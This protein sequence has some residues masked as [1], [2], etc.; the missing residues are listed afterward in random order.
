MGESLEISSSLMEN[1]KNIY[2][3]HTKDN[4]GNGCHHY[5]LEKEIVLKVKKKKNLYQQSLFLPVFKVILC[6]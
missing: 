5:S 6:I 1:L 2:I 4:M 3:N